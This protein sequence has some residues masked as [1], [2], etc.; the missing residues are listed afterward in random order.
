MKRPRRPVSRWR[1]PWHRAL[2]RKVRHRPRPD[3]RLRRRTWPRLRGISAVVARTVTAR[4]EEAVPKRQ[5]VCA[6]SAQR[7]VE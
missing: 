6:P 5:R 3:R 4:V 2:A 1:H 7:E